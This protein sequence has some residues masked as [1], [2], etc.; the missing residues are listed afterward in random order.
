MLKRVM[1]VTALIVAQ[2]LVAQAQSVGIASYYSDYYNGRLMANGQLFYNSSDSCAHRT[3]RFGTRIRITNIA[4]GT[5][6]TCT[7]RDRGPYVSGRIIDLSKETFRQI[8][9]LSQGIVRVKIEV[10]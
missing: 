7:V 1:A 6:T 4:T 5:S 10:L 2:P 3:L 9:P 8:A